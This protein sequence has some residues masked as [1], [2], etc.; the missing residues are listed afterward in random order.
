MKVS[1]IKRVLM[2]RMAWIAAKGERGQSS[3]KAKSFADA[4]YTALKELLSAADMFDPEAYA[5]Y[6]ANAQERLDDREEEEPS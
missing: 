4:E 5:R 2:T 3:P 6:L 1:K